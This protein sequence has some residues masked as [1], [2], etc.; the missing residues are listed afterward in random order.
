MYITDVRVHRLQAKQ[1]IKRCPPPVPFL[2]IRQLLLQSQGK[3]AKP[4]SICD[5][6]RPVALLFDLPRDTRT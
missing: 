1:C 4:W 3:A 5:R 6:G 2:A